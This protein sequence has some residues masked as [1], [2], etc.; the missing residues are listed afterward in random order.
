MRPPVLHRL[1]LP[2]AL[3]LTAS[4]VANTSSALAATEAATRGVLDQVLVIGKREQVYDIPGS[5]H[6]VGTRDIRELAYDD[7]N[8]ALRRVPGVYVR[9]E[10][11]YGLFPN[12]SLRG[13]DTTRS[14]KLTIMED[15]ILT[16]PAP[17]SAPAAYYS[18]TLGRMHA[19]AALGRRTGLIYASGAR[20]SFFRCSERL[21]ALLRRDA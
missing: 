21:V 10:D 13:V 15:G 20:R 19:L 9:E 18:P 12:I 14:A 4:T 11:G 5:A 16:A 2:G 7:V 3:L 8:R 1:A 6:V 17:Y